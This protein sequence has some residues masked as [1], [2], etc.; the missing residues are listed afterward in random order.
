MVRAVAIMFKCRIKGKD[1]VRI[2]AVDG[3]IYGV[4]MGLIIFKE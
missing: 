4:S 2:R 1:R 3:V